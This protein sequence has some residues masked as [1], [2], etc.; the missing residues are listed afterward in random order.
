M[1]V[2]EIMTLAVD[3]LSWH[4]ELNVVIT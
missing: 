3:I 1:S 4:S 2:Q